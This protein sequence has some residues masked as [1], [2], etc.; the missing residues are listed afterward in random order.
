MANFV[1]KKDGTKEPFDIEKIRKAVTAAAKRLNLPEEEIKKVVGRALTTTAQLA[2]GKNEITTMEIKEK[3]L[4]EL[5]VV[6]PSVSEAWRKY[7][8]EK[9]K[10]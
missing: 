8:R 4:A 5:D 7:E 3:I 9:T 6:A 10:I 2:G 1:I